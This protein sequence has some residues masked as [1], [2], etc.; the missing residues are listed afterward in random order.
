MRFGLPLALDAY[1]FARDG[2][3]GRPRW[4]AKTRT[5]SQKLATLQGS[6]RTLT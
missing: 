2:F 5:P 1:E 3:I 6:H 4:L